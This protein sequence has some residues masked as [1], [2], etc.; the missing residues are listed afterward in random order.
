MRF[1]PRSRARLP[2]QLLSPLGGA[3]L[4]R[5][6]YERVLGAF[7]PDRIWVV[8]AASLREAVAGELPEVAARRLISEP[9]QRNTAPAIGLVA[10]LLLREDPDAVMGTFPSDHHFERESAYRRALPRLLEATALDRLIVLGIEPAWPETGYG[11]I[12]FPVGT[13]PGLVEPT[14]VVQ[15][16]EKPDRETARRFVAAEHFFWNSG[17]FFWKAGVLAEE[18]RRY[19]PATWATLSWIARGPERSFETRLAERYAACESVSVDRAVLERSQRVSGFAVNDVGWSDIGSWDALHSLTPKDSHGNGALTDATFVNAQG[20]F[21]DVPGKHAAMVGV[22]DLVVVETSDALLI[23]RRGAAQ[24]VRSA[25][26]AVR[27][28]GRDDLL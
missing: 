5:R 27:K 6:T 20:N 14:P 13:G 4:L 15:F 12:E 28:S 17:Q 9:E 23:C 16:R 24:D 22:D 11:Y 8:T 10:A 26:D 1:W 3:S 18:M 2:K 7:E 19:L 25:V 21:V